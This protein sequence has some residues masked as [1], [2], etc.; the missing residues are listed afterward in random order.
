MP[1]LPASVWSTARTFAS[2]EFYAMVSFCTHAHTRTRIHSSSMS[3]TYVCTHR[4][5]GLFLQNPK[6]PL[7]NQLQPLNRNIPCGPLVSQLSGGG[8]DAVGWEDDAGEPRR[9]IPPAK[10]SRFKRM[11]SRKKNKKGN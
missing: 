10:E 1:V 4:L 5:R 6:S 7:Q 9:I 3:T 11:F 2:G 8:K